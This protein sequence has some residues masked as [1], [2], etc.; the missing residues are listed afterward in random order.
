[1]KWETRLKTLSKIGKV[2][3]IWECDWQKQR[4]NFL[5]IPT[6]MSRILF[7]KDSEQQLMSGILDGSL[8]GF[9]IASV[10]CPQRLIDEYQNNGFLWPPV[11]QKLSVS[12][13][14]LSDYMREQYEVEGVKCTEPTLCQTYHGVDLLLFTP[15]IRFYVEKGFK[16]YNLKRF[17]QY[18]PGCVFSPFV[19]KGNFEKYLIDKYLHF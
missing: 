18:I 1:M 15:L 7:S 10:H 3:F 12:E 16:V 5:Q 6:D 8:F 17:T 19:K 4:Q 14:M 13:D 11:I 2:E 9:A